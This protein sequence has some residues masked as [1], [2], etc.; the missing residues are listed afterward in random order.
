MSLLFLKA[1]VSIDVSRFAGLFALPHF[2]LSER[3]FILAQRLLG[4]TMTEVVSAQRDATTAVSTNPWTSSPGSATAAASPVP[5]CEYLVYLQQ[6]PTTVQNYGNS[7]MSSPWSANSDAMEAIEQELR[8]PSGAPVPSA[9]QLTMSMVLFSP[10]CG[11][12]LESKGPPRYTPQEG[13]HLHGPKVESYLR[14]GKNYA[15]IYGLI[16][17]SQMLLLIRQMARAST[18]STVSRV[19]LYTIGMMALGD[20]FASMA[21]LTFGMFADAAFLMLITTAFL[22]FIG[23]SF[24]GMKFLMEIWTVQAPERARRASEM[25][26]ANAAREATRNAAAQAPV[27]AAA[28]ADTLPAP[29]TALPLN[30]SG[31]TPVILPPDQDL[32]AAEA[33]DA[34]MVAAP[35]TTGTGGTTRREIGALYSRF[36]ILL[37]MIIFVSLH[38][39]SWPAWL[40]SAYTNTLAFL[41]LSFWTPQIYR[42]VMRNTR[43]PLAWEFI[44]GQSILRSLPFLYFFTVSDN[45]LFIK[46]DHTTALVLAGWVW[47]QLLLLLGQDVAGPRCFTPAGWAPPAYDYHPVLRGRRCRVWR[48]NG[49]GVN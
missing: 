14:V 32:A 47:T 31:A 5:H 46:T 30:N 29:A 44:F 13:L 1:L 8:F 22:S 38:A 7:Q 17:G 21:F 26:N 39:T 4:K 12:V 33:E 10:D 16:S 34:A 9:P 42:N 40:R 24:F 35:D 25:S 36:Y 3:S 28:D 18:P 11:F 48:S 2:A 49:T 45:I 41:Y 37:M 20:G 27:R 6:H 19:S 43:K 15:L 23:V